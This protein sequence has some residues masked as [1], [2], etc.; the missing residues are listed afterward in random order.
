MDAVDVLA[1]AEGTALQI[2]RLVGLGPTDTL[3]PSLLATALLG[4]GR[5]RIE[6]LARLGAVVRLPD[7]TKEILVGSH[8]RAE[9][10]EWVVGHELAHIVR[11]TEHR[12]GSIEE[13]IC[14]CVGA[15]IL[16][17]RRPF[18]A[19]I[20]RF[21]EDYSALAEAFGTTPESAARR[22]GEVTGEGR[23]VVTPRRVYAAG[24]VQ[25]LEE[26]ARAFALSGGPG[27]ATITI[28]RKRRVLKAI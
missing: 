19:A 17:P 23:I 9:N 16:M 12:S 8:V 27:I 11:G 4:R 7:G 13:V 28:G 15:C 22:W 24:A 2:Y 5:V 18:L 21:G 1:E 10:L 26:Q 20:G 6:H 3:R 25:I 14:D